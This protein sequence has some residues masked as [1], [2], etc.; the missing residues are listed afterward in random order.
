MEGNPGAG[1]GWNEDDNKPSSSQNSIL[2]KF[3]ESLDV[4]TV[5]VADFT[6]AGYTID[7]A[8]VV[9]ENEE[10]SDGQPA[11]QRV[12][13]AIT[14]TEDLT[15]N[16]RPSVSVSGV[17]DVAGNSHRN[18]DAHVGQQDKGHPYGG[19]VLGADSREGRAGH[20]LH[21]GRGAALHERRQVDRGVG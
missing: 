8:E 7:S 6:V 5:A 19:V 12:R 11:P 15:K 2:V 17:S 1:Q 20:H 3:N 13:G 18:D 9:G 10:D 16:A 14:L 4:D 21:L